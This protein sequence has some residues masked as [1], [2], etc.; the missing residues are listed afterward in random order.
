MYGR[1][2]LRYPSLLPMRPEVPAL[3]ETW[4]DEFETVCAE[5][6][7]IAM[8]PKS[9]VK[10]RFVLLFLAFVFSAGISVLAQEIDRDYNKAV[11][12]SRFRTYRWIP[13]SMLLRGKVPENR[14]ADAQLEQIITTAID[15]ELQSR[16]LRP[17]KGDE[18]DLLVNYLGLV[19]YRIL[20]LEA[21]R[22]ANRSDEWIPYK[23]LRPGYEGAEQGYLKRYGTLSI[24][25]VA[26]ET[27]ALVWRGTARAALPS[28][29][30]DG[31][32]ERLEDAEQK[33]GELIAK[34]LSEFP[35]HQ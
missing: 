1:T 21:A 22:A 13:K 11:D 14:V 33:L 10:S 35:P 5:S 28:P 19:S 26:S 3:A 23:P 18:A 24:D 7:R 25:L 16:G 17:A 32:T 34:V 15:R 4:I 8:L 2:E 20:D 12:F 29:I 9:A 27:N 30:E 6:R 31:D